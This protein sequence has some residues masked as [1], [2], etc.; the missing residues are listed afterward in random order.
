[1][2]HKDASPLAGQTVTIK[3]GQFAGQEYRVE[4]WW[5]RLGLGS[6]MF[7]AGN[8]ACIMYAIRTADD[9][10]PID[11]DVLYGKIGSLG[12]LVHLSEIEEG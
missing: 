7:A 9:D 3:S 12:H 8:P 6:W 10:L 2:Q 5:D 11:D 4:D 1:M